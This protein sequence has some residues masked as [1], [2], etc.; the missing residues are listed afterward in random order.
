MGGLVHIQHDLTFATF[1]DDPVQDTD[2]VANATFTYQWYRRDAMGTLT[3]ISGATGDSYTFCDADAGR[4][5]VVKGSF[6]DDKGNAE[7]VESRGAFPAY[8]LEAYVRPRTLP[9][10]ACDAPSMV[11]RTEVWREELTVGVWAEDEVASFGWDPDFV[12]GRL[13]SNGNGFFSIGEADYHLDGH[14]TLRADDLSNNQLLDPPWSLR[15]LLR[16]ALSEAR[17]LDPPRHRRVLRL[18]VCNDAFD[19]GSITE[20]AAPWYIF[21][22]PGLDW[23]NHATRTVYLSVDTP[24]LEQATVNGATLKLRYSEAL[25]TTAPAAAAYEVKVGGTAASPTAVSIAGNT[26]TLTLGT[27][28]SA[29]PTVTLTYRRGQAVNRV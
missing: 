23:Q 28:V 21:K 13:S 16:E 12:D 24:Q 17:T 7:E 10:T 14:L 15:I 18:H 11:G 1:S 2:G 25:E 9:A 22:D 4:K 26:V 5:V 3:P 20:D 19:F 6:R 27:A 8:E 29:G